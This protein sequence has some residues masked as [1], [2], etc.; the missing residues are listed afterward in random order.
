MKEHWSTLD[1]VVHMCNRYFKEFQ[2]AGLYKDRQIVLYPGD[3]R[4]FDVKPCTIGVVQR[5]G[6]EGKGD[7]FLQKAWKE[8]Q[9]FFRNEIKL[10]IKGKGWNK[11]NF[12]DISS[13]EFD[14]NEDY[15]TYQDFYHSLDY[16]LIPSLWEGGPMSLLEALACGLPVISSRVGFVEDLIGDSLHE[17][18]MLYSPNDVK[19]L[20]QI[21]EDIAITKLNRRMRIEGLSY[22]GYT[23]ELKKFFKEVKNDM[24]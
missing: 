8:L 2:K 11:S 17:G 14:E 9:P 16:L 18:H 21:L 6:F 1:G 19:G 7:G 10:K 24:A 23:K 20:V 5:G 4:S 22:S 12:C 3:V 13:V 15:E